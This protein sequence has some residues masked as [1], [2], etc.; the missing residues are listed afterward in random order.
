MSDTDIIPWITKQHNEYTKPAECDTS[1][2]GT[3]RAS[4]VHG[5][6]G[7]RR[8]QASAEVGRSGG[9]SCSNRSSSARAEAGGVVGGSEAGASAASAAPRSRTSNRGRPG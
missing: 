5:V 8:A 2:D 4:V 1:G 7:A 3:G 9:A 6:A